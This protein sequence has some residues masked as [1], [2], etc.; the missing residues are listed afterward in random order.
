MFALRL[1][2]DVEL[3]PLE[4]WRA[5]E[6]LAH[7]DRAREHIAPWVGPSFVA[8]DLD[9]ARAVLRRY[10]DRWARDGGGIW[11]LWRRGTLVGG[12]MLVSFDVSLGVCEVGCWLEP[13]AQGHGLVFRAVRHVVDWAVQER[14]I[15][16]VEWRTKPDNVRSIAL[17]RRLGLRHE[18]TL[19]EVYP[20]PS[21]RIDIQVWSV[22]AD[23]WRASF[24]VEG[25][26]PEKDPRPVG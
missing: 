23:E 5:E 26:E 15:H 9:S 4:P 8:T 12:V 21:G 20:G 2:S 14:G 19:R 22:L 16:R 11:G 17:A 10:A 3:R 6:F 25:G 13:S 7:L 24:P 1:T 18:G